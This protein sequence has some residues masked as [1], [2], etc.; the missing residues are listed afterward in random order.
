[1]TGSEL[2]RQLIFN[3]WSHKLR[4]ALALVGI[5]WGT[6]AVIL[7]LSI[8][9]AFTKAS[10]KNLAFL[11]N[12]TILGFAASTTKSYRGMPQGTQLHIRQHDYDAAIPHLDHLLAST[13]VYADS[14]AVQFGNVSGQSQ[15]QGVSADYMLLQNVEV[16]STG[17]FFDQVDLDN[18]HLVAFI[19]NDLEKSLSPKKSLVGMKILI[20]GIPFTVIG[21]QKKKDNGMMVMG[22]SVYIPYTTFLAIWGQKDIDMLMLLPTEVGYSALL[23]S[24]LKSALAFHFHY[25]PTDTNAI[26]IPDFAEAQVFFKWF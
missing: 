22:G 20:S 19:N 16:Q 14:K 17:R 26:D 7:L 15:V 1:M 6:I 9:S 13:P 21:V 5:I 8:S 3:F 25:D 24:E 4:T 18:H 12:G 11:N 23:K 10:K 2:I